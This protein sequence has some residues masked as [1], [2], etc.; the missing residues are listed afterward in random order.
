VALCKDEDDKIG[1]TAI[2]AAAMTMFQ[3]AM[4]K[5]SLK[6]ASTGLDR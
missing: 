3:R 5:P 6:T 1:R 4:P 2:T